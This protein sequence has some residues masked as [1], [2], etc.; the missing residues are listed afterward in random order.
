MKVDEPQFFNGYMKR[1]KIVPHSMQLKKLSLSLGTLNDYRKFGSNG[2]DF[3]V[4]QFLRR[5]PTTPQFVHFDNFLGALGK[6]PRCGQVVHLC[7]CSLQIVQKR[8]LLSCCSYGA[9]SLL[10]VGLPRFL[11]LSGASRLSPTL[12]SSLDAVS[13]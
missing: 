11:S 8:D 7:P 3:L 1:K 12:T 4:P 6:S 2:P 5:C 10:V 9:L 13:E